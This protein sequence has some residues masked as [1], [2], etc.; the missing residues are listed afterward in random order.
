M[1]I[2]VL[3]QNQHVLQPAD[4]YPTTDGQPMA[5]TEIHLL[6]MLHLI[7]ALR[8][9]FRQQKDVYVIGNMLFYYHKGDPQARRAPD[10]M[11]A[12]SLRV[13]CNGCFCVI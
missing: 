13:L 8:Y 11:V 4:E 2:L 1:C 9:F 7:G 10:V 12:F 3:E 6:A 5:E